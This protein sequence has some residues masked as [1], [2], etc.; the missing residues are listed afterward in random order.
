[1]K[2]FLG[3]VAYDERTIDRGS[4]EDMQAEHTAH[5][6]RQQ[7]HE[8]NSVCRSK[9]TFLIVLSLSFG[10]N[11]P[12]KSKCCANRNGWFCKSNVHRFLDAK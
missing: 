5:S 4:Q 7:Y 11:S 8:Y 10:M 12:S 1:M 9:V 3:R 6:L 2:A